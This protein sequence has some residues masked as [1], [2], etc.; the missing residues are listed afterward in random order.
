MALI[1][2]QPKK[3]QGHS[4]EMISLV[5]DVV[6]TYKTQGYDLTLR[7]VYYQMVA[8]GYIP[9]NDKE[10]KKLG[11]LIN[12]ARLAGEIDWKS[13]EDRT[14]NLRGNSHWSSPGAIISSCAYQYEIDKWI[15]QE[16]HVEVWVEK[17]ALVGI[18]GTACTPFDVSYFS[19]RGYVSQSEMWIAAHRLMNKSSEQGKKCIILHLGDH[20]PSGI[21]MSRDIEARI[22]MFWQHHY[23]MDETNDPYGNFQFQRIALNWDQVQQYNPPPNPTK[24]KD[25]RSTK[26]VRDYGMECWELDALEPRVI[27]QLIRE[28][29]AEYCDA[30]RFAAKQEEEQQA[31]DLLSKVATNWKLVTQFL[32]G[33]NVTGPFITEVGPSA[34]IID[35]TV[36]FQ[37]WVEKLYDEVQ[38]EAYSIKTRKALRKALITI[39]IDVDSFHEEEDTLG[40]FNVSIETDKSRDELDLDARLID[41]LYN[42]GYE[43]VEIE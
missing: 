31:K 9:N 30:Q 8:R 41:E 43:D 18:I 26:Y 22:R 3:F 42:A 23:Y 34:N 5:N 4:K 24:L 2:Y 28:H 10:Y 36:D 25:A 1:C 15:D 40:V 29:I 11:S 12:D 20:D 21:D 32:N 16:Y 35:I 19:C 27:D 33:D 7:Q 14:R 17:D 38:R 39:G 6:V 37:P 13:I